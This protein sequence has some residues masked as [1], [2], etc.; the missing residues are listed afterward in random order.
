MA[1]RSQLSDTRRTRRDKRHA[2]LTRSPADVPRHHPSPVDREGLA[3]SHRQEDTLFDRGVTQ[4]ADARKPEVRARRPDTDIG[5]GEQ[6][7]P[8]HSLLPGVGDA[9]P[10]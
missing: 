1:G 8:R 10:G 5:S 9:P 2:A 7:S 3:G 6:V 4:A